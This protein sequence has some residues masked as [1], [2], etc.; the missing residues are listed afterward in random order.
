ME[1]GTYLEDGLAFC[2]GTRLD[3]WRLYLLALSGR[4]SGS[5][6]ANGMRQ[7]IQREVVLR[8]PRSAHVARV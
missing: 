6:V 2:E 8:N 3:T 7:P 5:C 1:I 4:P